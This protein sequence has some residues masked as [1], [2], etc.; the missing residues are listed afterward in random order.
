MA[1][2]INQEKFIESIRF[3]PTFSVE[4]IEDELEKS[5]QIFGNVISLTICEG[6]DDEDFGK[7]LDFLTSIEN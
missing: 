1:L 2:R 4:I 5:I 7:I 6:V 3:L